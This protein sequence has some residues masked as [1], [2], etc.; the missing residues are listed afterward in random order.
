MIAY[1]KGGSTLLLLFQPGVLAWDDDLVSNSSQSLETLVTHLVQALLILATSWS[2][3]WSS[4]FYCSGC[5]RERED[6]EC[7]GG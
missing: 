2:E 3:R 1:C 5:E 6:G 4:S 7:H